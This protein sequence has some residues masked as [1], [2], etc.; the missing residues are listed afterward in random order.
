[1]SEAK[2]TSHHIQIRIL[3]YTECRAITA[4]VIEKNVFVA[5]MI[6]TISCIKFVLKPQF[7]FIFF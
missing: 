4:C 6:L 2:E 1:M 3:L 5:C 7:S